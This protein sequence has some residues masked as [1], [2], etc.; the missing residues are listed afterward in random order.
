M[1]G[2]VTYRD[3]TVRVPPDAVDDEFI[4][5]LGALIRRISADEPT[6]RVPSRQEC[7]Y[8]D[9][10]AEDCPVRVDDAFQPEAGATAD[11]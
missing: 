6:R 5:N 1:R 2:K 3:H 7:R 9:V 11:F 10:T 4:Q 8:R